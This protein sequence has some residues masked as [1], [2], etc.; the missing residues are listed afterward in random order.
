MGHTRVPVVSE[1]RS[2][3]VYSSIAG[4]ILLSGCVTTSTIPEMSWV[5]RTV[6]RSPMTR[7]YCSKGRAILLLAMP[8]SIAERQPHRR[9]DAWPRRGTCLCEGIRQR[10]CARHTPQVLN[11]VVLADSVY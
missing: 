2:N 3:L 8:I 10:T 7:R 11:A 1:R 6:A 9:A 5:E 4:L